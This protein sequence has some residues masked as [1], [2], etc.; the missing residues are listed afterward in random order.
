[1]SKVGKRNQ[2]RPERSLFINLYTE[3]YGTALLLSMDWLSLRLIH[4]QV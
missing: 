3:V 2:G 4:I 1:M